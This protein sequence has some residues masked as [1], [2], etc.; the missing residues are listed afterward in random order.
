MKFFKKNS[1]VS[2]DSQSKEDNFYPL[3]FTANYLKTAEK[4]I[5]SEELKSMK[6]I[7]KLKDSFHLLIDETQIL[8]GG[9]SSFQNTFEEIQ[10]TAGHFSVVKDEISESVSH[11][12]TQ[13]TTLKNSSS[14]VT[15]GFSQIEK[16]FD[17]FKNAVMEI[18]SCMMGI[19]QIANQTNLLALNA[20]IEAARAGEAGRG[21]SI[22]AEKVQELA[23]EIKELI[24]SVDQSIQKVN[25][26]YELLD[27]N[28]KT[29]KQALENSIQNVDKTDTI[30]QD[31]ISS[32]EKT[33]DV[34]NE[35]LNAIS[36][37]QNEQQKL[38]EYF[39]T[40]QQK[41]DDVLKN[42]ENM[43]MLSTQKSSMFEQLNDM[44]SQLTP[45][46]KDMEK[47]KH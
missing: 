22:V 1:P 21:F 34:Y 26:D 5:V 2:I 19:V 46:L 31:I 16:S 24:S 15:D 8:E 35:I 30:F 41:Y 43:N 11:A 38:T 10:E 29:S 40:T 28:L 36:N 13:V 23:V 47:E 37:S 6:E 7:D 42:I 12:Q 18:Q 25:A 20:S 17:N 39:H 9:V 32:A 4:N 3:Y 27:K 33:G 45:L 14:K 44:I